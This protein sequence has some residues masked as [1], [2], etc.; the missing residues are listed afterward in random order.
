MSF[1][2]RA[3]RRLALAFATVLIL[4][5]AAHAQAPDVRV[6]T[7][8]EET[9][10]LGGGAE[11]VRNVEISY[12]YVANQTIQTVRD[13]SGVIIETSLLGRAPQPNE[14]EI[15]EA[16]DLVYAD[17][18]LGPIASRQGNVVEGGFLL[19]EGDCEQARCIQLHIGSIDGSRTDRFVVVDLSSSVIVHRNLFPDLLD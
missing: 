11:A 1:V 12:D 19:Y 18:E 9:V 5:S 10:K 3:P 8:Y 15:A 6:I 7:T 2:H 14:E 4:S 16:I 17:D 13:A